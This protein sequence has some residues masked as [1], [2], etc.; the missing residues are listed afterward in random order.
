MIDELERVR[1]FRASQ[2]RASEP[3]TLIARARLME[4]IAKATQES[5]HV[6][7][8]P[9]H[10]SRRPWRWSRVGVAAVAAGAMAVLAIIV[11]IG[12][13]S[14]SHAAAAA[15]RRLAVV[16]ANQ[17][18]IDPPQPGQY[19]YVESVQANEVIG[20]GTGCVALVPE[21]RQLW[22]DAH[23]A[24][25]LL[26]TSGQSSFLTATARSAC[27]R[28]HNPFLHSSGINDA[29]FAARCL[30]LGL[31]SRVYG[32]FENPPTLLAEMRQIEG[33][34]PGPAED[35]V[36]I[37]DSLRESD[38]SPALRA[39]IYRAAATIPGVRLIRSTTDRLGRRGEAVSYTSHSSTSEL[40]F[41]PRTSALLGEQT[42]D[43]KTGQLTGWAAYQP[44]KIVDHV[45][46]RPPAPLSPSCQTDGE[47]VARVIR[48]VSVITGPP[49]GSARSST[50]RS[51][52][53][54]AQQR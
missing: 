9:R 1:E 40:I 36:H 52:L 53:Q 34:P 23:G 21:R 37:G 28:V 46:G 35:F 2:P 15:L 5:Q 10:R 39:A 8:P 29:W 16:A 44:T 26:E 6:N 41:D 17:S 30:T 27:E 48:G 22:I 31:G 11:G 54:P 3:A 43:T 47:G 19:M 49:A 45:P 25:R 38:D 50:G 33:G 7:D 32:D 24:G 12:S 51:E 4:Q 20:G 13:T 18:P 14:P 42:V